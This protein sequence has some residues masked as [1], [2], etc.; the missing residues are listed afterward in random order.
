VRRDPIV[1]VPYDPAWPESFAAQRDRI[2]P[3]P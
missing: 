1:I 2:T 3:R